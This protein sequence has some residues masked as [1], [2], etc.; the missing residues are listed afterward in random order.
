MQTID[1]SPLQR[2]VQFW[3]GPFFKAFFFLFDNSCCRFVSSHINSFSVESLLLLFFI[4]FFADFSQR[5]LNRSFAWSPFDCPLCICLVACLWACAK[6][7]DGQRKQ[8][9]NRLWPRSNHHH[10]HH[11]ACLHPPLPRCL[12]WC[13]ATMVPQ[14]TS[15]SMRT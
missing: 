4:T 2:L 3:Y 14:T 13:T 8:S 11:L 9:S 1:L 10:H 15:L 12:Y 6:R 7:S 5:R